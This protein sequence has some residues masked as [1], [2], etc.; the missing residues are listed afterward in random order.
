MT[1]PV[2]KNVY[3]IGI[4]SGSTGNITPFVNKGAPSSS[5]VI[6]PNG[7]FTIGQ[8]F[9]DS[10]N[11]NGYELLGLTSSSGTV[12]ATWGQTSSSLVSFAGGNFV[13]STTGGGVVLSPIVLSGTAASPIIANG[14]SGAL[15]FTSVSLAA[16][17]DLTLTITNSSI[18]SSS[19]QVL[20]SFYGATTGSALQIKSV[21]NSAGTSV[22]VI[23]N[24]VGATT[25]T[26]NITLTFLVL[27]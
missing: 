2:A 13:S 18:I 19:T 26:S 12:T 25:S 3:G 22:I 5:N 27:N 1:A 16:N 17:A 21:T 11:L 7:P 6:G 8:S 4:G 24:G 10:T 14:R 15:T 9:I 20:Y 23:T